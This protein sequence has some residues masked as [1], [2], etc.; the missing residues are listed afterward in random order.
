[1]PGLG[2]TRLRS[3]DSPPSRAR[4]TRLEQ[5]LGRIHRIGQDRDVHAFN[6]VASESEEGQPIIEGRIL[7][8]LL[9]KMEQMRNAL[10]AQSRNK[11]DTIGR[12]AQAGG[13][14]LR[15]CLRCKSNIAIFCSVGFHGLTSLS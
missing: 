10:A 5:R 7:E 3:P 12:T 4:Q 11:I 1:M 8:R 9:Q 13:M 15:W 14:S 6:F 2:Q